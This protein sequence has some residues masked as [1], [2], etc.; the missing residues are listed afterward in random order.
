MNF[1]SARMK[2]K[3]LQDDSLAFAGRSLPFRHAKAWLLSLI[4]SEKSTEFAHIL[5]REIYNYM[6]VRQLYFSRNFRISAQIW[7]H[8]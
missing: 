4:F 5:K 3:T 1:S 6:T 7:G 8:L 2:A